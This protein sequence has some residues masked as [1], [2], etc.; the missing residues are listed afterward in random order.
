MKVGGP[1]F[2][3]QKPHVCGCYN[4]DITVIF[5]DPKTMKRQLFCINHGY[6]EEET[7]IIVA[8]YP[9]PKPTDEWREKE[10]NRLR[11]RG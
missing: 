3:G 9:V 7:K 8:V 10:R 11:S 2:S 5:D 1:Y 4:P 6:V